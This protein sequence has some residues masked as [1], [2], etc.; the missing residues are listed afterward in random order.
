MTEFSDQTTQQ[1]DAAA[2]MIKESRLAVLF[3]GA[4][5]STPSGIAD[6][7]SVN[8]GLWTKDN[9]MEVASLTVFRENPQRFFDWLYP[10]AKQISTASPNHGHYAIAELQNRGLIK[11]VITQNIDHLHQDAGSNE[12]LELHGT[13]S[14]ATCL[15]CQRS[16]Q[17]ADYLP[18]YIKSGIIPRCKQCGR[19]LKPDIVLFEELLPALVWESA[20]DYCGSCDLMIVAGSSL[21]VIPA[22][23]LPAKAARSG[24][25]VIILNRTATFLDD[26]ADLVIADDLVQVLPALLDRVG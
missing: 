15:G 2:R 5:I 13:I 16:I 21:E 17:A 25:R 4:G 20:D 18:D 26:Q 3:S 1:L 9:P 19:I 8:T 10:L 14:T 23:T 6:F 12:V 7:R 24:A 22:A 11:T